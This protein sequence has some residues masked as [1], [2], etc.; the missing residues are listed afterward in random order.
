MNK[1]GRFMSILVVTV[2]AL[3]S[4]NAQAWWGNNDDWRGGPWYG[5]Y[6]GYG[7]YGWG[8]PYGPYGWGGPWG[9]WGGPWGGYGNRNPST[10]IINP[11]SG[12]ERTPPPPPPK[13]P[14]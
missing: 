13:I 10:I 5:G 3:A 2:A 8:G 14:E 7:G 1:T 12:S 9:G 11:S 6:P 4:G